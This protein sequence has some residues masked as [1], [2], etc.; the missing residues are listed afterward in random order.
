MCIRDRLRAIHISISMDNIEYL[1]STE[2]ISK[3]TKEGRV[4]IKVNNM[5][6]FIE[7]LIALNFKLFMNKK[8]V[9]QFLTKSG[10]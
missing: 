9:H 6:P 5:H 8:I 10:Y 7:K 2:L 1:E 3:E 4:I